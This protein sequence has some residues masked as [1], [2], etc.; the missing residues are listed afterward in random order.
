MLQVALAEWC[1]FVGRGGRTLQ[2]LSRY[3]S[4]RALIVHNRAPTVREAETPARRK[5]SLINTFAVAVPCTCGRPPV[6][7]NRAPTV[8]EAETPARR[9]ALR[10][11]T[12][13][14]EVPCTCGRTS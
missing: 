14:V 2:V 6:V 11:N 3:L 13:A 4:G 1:F 8:R 5:A 7:H 12:F 9:K 10:I